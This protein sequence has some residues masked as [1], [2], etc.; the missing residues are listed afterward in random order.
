MYVPYDL[1]LGLNEEFSNLGLLQLNSQIPGCPGYLIAQML[2]SG[3]CVYN[4]LLQT[5]TLT[6]VQLL[7]EL[8]DNTWG[9]PC[10]FSG[11]RK[12]VY[13]YIYVCRS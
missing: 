5:G 4:P 7:E 12:V 13:I 6:W 2:G 11:F 10:W 9:I 1:C 8:V 3:L